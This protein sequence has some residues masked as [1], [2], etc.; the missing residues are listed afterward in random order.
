M[1][2]SLLC[3]WPRAST[4]K[5]KADYGDLGSVGGRVSVEVAT[6][7]TRKEQKTELDLRVK[8]DLMA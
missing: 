2:C 8:A 6:V 5:S 3:K 7:S 4:I 1:Q